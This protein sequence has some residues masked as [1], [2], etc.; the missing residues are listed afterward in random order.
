MTDLVLGKLKRVE[1]Q[2]RGVVAMYEE[3]RDCLDIAQQ[4]AAARSALGA[5]AKDLLTSE[6]VRCAAH[7]KEKTKLEQTL[8]RLFEIG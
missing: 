7:P 5:V 1:G 2:V 4:I 8:K 6:S 3:G